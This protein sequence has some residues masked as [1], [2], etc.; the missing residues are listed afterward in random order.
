MAAASNIV[1]EI[2]GIEVPP[3][4]WQQ[5]IF[6][7]GCGHGYWSKDQ[8]RDGDATCPVRTNSVVRPIMPV[9]RPVAWMSWISD[10]AR[11]VGRRP[12]G[13]WLA[14]KLLRIFEEGRARLALK[15]KKQGRKRV[16]APS[17]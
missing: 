13:V 17:L 2:L 4:V 16:R 7:L 14:Q 9:S 3:H 1:K 12:A 6:P 5:F 15:K 10:E 8:L 11:R